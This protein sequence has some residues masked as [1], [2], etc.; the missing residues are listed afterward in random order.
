V[1]HDDRSGKF[2]GEQESY[3]ACKNAQYQGRAAEYLEG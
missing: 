3:P 1:H 2:Y